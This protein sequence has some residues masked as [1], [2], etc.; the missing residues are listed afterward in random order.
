M[1]PSFGQRL[2]LPAPAASAPPVAAGTFPREI[3]GQFFSREEA[4][5]IECLYRRVKVGRDALLSVIRDQA[6]EERTLEVG[7]VDLV[8]GKMRPRLRA[9]GLAIVAAGDTELRMDS[10][11]KANVREALVQLGAET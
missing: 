9:A 2:A 1:P 10:V 3:G 8:I 4:A 11:G 6:G 7:H 5:I